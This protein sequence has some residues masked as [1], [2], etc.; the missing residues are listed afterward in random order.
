MTEGIAVYG[1]DGPP[2]ADADANDRD[3]GEEYLTSQV[4]DIPCRTE[5]PVV[6]LPI[7]HYRHHEPLSADEAADQVAGLFAEL[8]GRAEPWTLPGAAR[9][10]TAAEERLEDWAGPPEP[11]S[12]VLFWAGHGE[13]SPEGA[14]LAVH[15]TPGSM[16]TRGLTPENFAAFIDAEWSRRISDPHAWAVV[17]IEACGAERFADLVAV[18]LLSGDKPRRLAV[19]GVGGY[20]AGHLGEFAHALSGALASYTDNDETIRL[21]DLMLRLHD[22]MQV[23]SIH[24]DAFDLHL[25]PPLPRARLLPTGVTSP[26][27]VYAELRTFLARLTADER[28]HFIPKAQ[29]AEQGELAWYFVGRDRERADI[30]QWLRDK[31]RGLLI[32]TGSPGAGKSALL[33]NMV[34]Q[35]NPRLRD[36]LVR[37]GHLRDL[38]KAERPPD[39]VFDAVVHLT[40]ITMA[41]LVR[42]LAHSAM[43]DD[44]PDTGSTAQ[45]IEWLLNE[46]GQ[47][48]VPFTILVD[49]LDEAQEP[50]DIARSLLRRLAVLPRVRVVVGTRASTR[51][52]PD[53]PENGDRDLLDALG[54]RETVRVMREPDALGRYVRLRLNHA[55]EAGVLPAADPASIDEVAR[56]ITAYDRHFLYARLA[57]HE[58]LAAPHLLTPDGNHALVSLL[59]RDHRSLFAAA[60]ERLADRSVAAVPLLEALALAQG[61]GLPRADRIWAVAA[62][63]LGD[64]VPV[65]DL[66]IDRLLEAAA[67][68]VMLD[69]EHGQSVYRLSHRTFQEHFLD[70]PWQAT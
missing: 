14:W 41:E 34:V 57:V 35:A 18:R 68:Y 2:Y 27:D 50:L 49:A 17:V 45:D 43:L 25:A 58:I 23:G 8:G 52:G 36:L 5:F 37:G 10:R 65:T 39:H 61:R 7:G 63:A 47:S 21:P 4:T 44:L 1:D 70:Q 66:D 46:L 56:Q 24:A 11:R 59:R 31:L 42:R 6:C 13:A 30:S 3:N 53:R 40:G 32:V 62:T 28:S 64:G 22:R 19:I 16:R 69:F 20:G 29:G 60:V 38:P 9:D 54:A 26:L 67:P 51:E 33:G 12:S 15:E 55:R 48:D